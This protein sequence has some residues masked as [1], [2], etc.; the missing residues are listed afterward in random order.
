MG[1]ANE[2]YLRINDG[3]DRRPV[4]ESDESK[5]N[6]AIQDTIAEGPRQVE[7]DPSLRDRI[8][9]SFLIIGLVRPLA[10]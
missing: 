3:V 5:D 10:K 1:I 7:P 2:G 8:L 4:N 6:E 9:F